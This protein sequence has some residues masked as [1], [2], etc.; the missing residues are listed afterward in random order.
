MCFECELC[1]NSEKVTSTSNGPEEVGVALFAGLDDASISK[2]KFRAD[3]LVDC[4]AVSTSE[5]A[6][7]EAPVSIGLYSYQGS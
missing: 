5:P 3:N 1:D 2:Y 4:K 7:G 6:A